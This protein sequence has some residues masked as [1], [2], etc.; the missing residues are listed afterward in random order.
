MP[1]ETETSVRATLKLLERIRPDQTLLSLATSYPGT[2]LWDGP[3]VDVPTQWV[4]SF[5]GHGDGGSLLLS[6]TLD[7]REYKRLADLLRDGI[8]RLQSC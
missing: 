5:G 4:K 7:R 2:E 3:F 1:G 8:R 6:E